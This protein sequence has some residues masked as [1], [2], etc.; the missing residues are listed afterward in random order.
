MNI[1]TKIMYK[2]RKW[3]TN[4]TKGFLLAKEI[5]DHIITVKKEV[6]LKITN[7]L[8]VTK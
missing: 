6:Y 3:I 5:F 2:R 4:K 7:N 1:L 8:S